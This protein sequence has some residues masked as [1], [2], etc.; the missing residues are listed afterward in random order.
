MISQLVA[1]LDVGGTVSASSI[2]RFSLLLKREISRQYFFHLHWRGLNLLSSLVGRGF[3]CSL[4]D[5]KL[6]LAVVTVFGGG[7]HGVGGWFHE[8][9]WQTEFFKRYLLGFNY[10]SDS[11]I[12][13]FKND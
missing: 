1:L 13:G 11:Y 10:L 7:E 12:S 4:R 9:L 6:D 5:L 8:R 3:S 2:H